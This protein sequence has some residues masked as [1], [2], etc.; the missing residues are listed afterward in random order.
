VKTEFFDGFDGE[1]RD[2]LLKMA[3]AVDALDSQDLADTIL[4]AV[5]RPGNV[6]LNE[7]II[8]PTKQP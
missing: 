1:K 7:I 6:S 8:R 5:S 2:N 4:F 3:E